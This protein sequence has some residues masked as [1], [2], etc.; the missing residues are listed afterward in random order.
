MPPPLPGF[1]QEQAM[2]GSKQRN[3]NVHESSEGVIGYMRV[4]GTRRGE[5]VCA[6]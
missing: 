6:G 2:N 3:G 4:F 5:V 1:F